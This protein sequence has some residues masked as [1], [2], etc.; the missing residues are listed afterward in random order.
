ML[1]GLPVLHF[2][3]GLVDCLG[4]GLNLSSTT[5]VLEDSVR[6]LDR[7][8]GLLDLNAGC[9]KFGTVAFGR[10]IDGLPTCG[11]FVGQVD[12]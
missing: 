10:F 4:G 12:K 7:L 9:L 2:S 8:G 1:S 6:F 11:L 5:G 3:F